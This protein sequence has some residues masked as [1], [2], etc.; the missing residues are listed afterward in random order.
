MVKVFGAS[1]YQSNVGINDK[2]IV[3]KALT[4]Y[5]FFLNFGY[6]CI[7]QYFRFC[8]KYNVPA[9]LN[10][11]VYPNMRKN[12]NMSGPFQLFIPGDHEQIVHG[13][14]AFLIVETQ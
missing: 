11:T 14:I 13:Q 2:Y 1:L 8:C 6:F 4:E 7:S 12:Q 5:W 10:L 3:R 9:K